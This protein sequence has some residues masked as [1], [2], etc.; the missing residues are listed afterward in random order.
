[1]EYTLS[2]CSGHPCLND[3]V[4]TSDMTLYVTGVKLGLISGVI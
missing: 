4:M 1:M 3:I 2:S